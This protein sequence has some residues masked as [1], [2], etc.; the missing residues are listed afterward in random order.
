MGSDSKLRKSIKENERLRAEN[1][2]L[3]ERCSEQD[4]LILDL[5]DAREELKESL[6]H[7]L[8]SRDF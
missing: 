6:E 4:R 1:K 5:N 7:S 2:M 8:D 3:R